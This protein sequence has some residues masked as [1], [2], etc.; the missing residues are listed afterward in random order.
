MKIPAMVMLGLKN[1]SFYFCII[2]YD[3][4]E[5]IHPSIIIPHFMAPYT[6]WTQKRSNFHSSN[7]FFIFPFF[8]RKGIK[9]NRIL[10]SFFINDIDGKSIPKYSMLIIIVMMSIIYKIS[11]RFAISY[12]KGFI[13]NDKQ[14]DALCS[15]CFVVCSLHCLKWQHLLCRYLITTA[16]YLIPY[17]INTK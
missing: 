14:K 11:L 7:F 15:I 12:N 4:T 8:C 16:S 5:S 6:G 2:E 10:W 1:T 13:G 3:P 17:F 9:F